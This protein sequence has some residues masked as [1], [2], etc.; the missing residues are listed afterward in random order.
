[1]ANLK[2][3]LPEVHAA[4]I[5]ERDAYMCNSILSVRP[6]CYPAAPPR[7]CRATRALTRRAEQAGARRMVA[8]VGMAHLDGIDAYPP[9]PSP[10]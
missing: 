9:P 4:M 5:S 3:S 7:A 10:Y 6:R 1:M 2:E 8:V